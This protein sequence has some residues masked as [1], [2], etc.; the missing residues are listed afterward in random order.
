MDLVTGLGLVV[1]ILYTVD[2]TYK[3]ASRFFKK[4]RVLARATR[5]DSLTFKT[6]SHFQLPIG[7]I[8]TNRKSAIEQSAIKRPTRY[9]VVVLTSSDRKNC[10]LTADWNSIH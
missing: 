4:K 6:I 8:A 2:L 10:E 5:R 3:S 1:G 9:R 7:F